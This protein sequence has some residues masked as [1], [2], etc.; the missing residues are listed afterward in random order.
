MAGKLS[1]VL[2]PDSPARATCEMVTFVRGFQPWGRGRPAPP[3]SPV[4]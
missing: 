1:K 3:N 4:E 2:T